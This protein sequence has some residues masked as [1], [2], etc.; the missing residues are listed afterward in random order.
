MKSHD[1]HVYMQILILLA[2]HDLLPKGI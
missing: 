2:F 1:C